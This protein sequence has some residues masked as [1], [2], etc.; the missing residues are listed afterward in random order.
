MPICHG[1]K[2]SYQPVVMIIGTVICATAAVCDCCTQYGSRRS[3]RDTQSW[4]HGIGSP[5]AVRSPSDSGT[6]SSARCS[7]RSGPIIVSMPVGDSMTVIM[8]LHVR[9]FRSESAPWSHVI[10]PKSGVV[11]ASDIASAAFSGS[12]AERA[13]APA[14]HCV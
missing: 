8:R 1:R 5:T 14:A 6:V 12:P 13:P 10:A 7:L 2:M 3:S 11:T 9:E 4:Y